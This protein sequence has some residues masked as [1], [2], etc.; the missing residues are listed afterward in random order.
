[1]NKWLLLLLSLAT[2]SVNAQKKSAKPPAGIPGA[3]ELQKMS[4]MTPAELE[5]YQQKLIRQLEGQAAAFADSA[6]IV[7]DES[8]FESFSIK[9]PVKDVKKLAGIAVQ[10][11]TLPQLVTR[12]LA[13]EQ[14]L[15][16]MMTPAQLAQAGEAAEGRPASELSSAMISSWYGQN[17]LTALLMAVKTTQLVPDHLPAWNN[18]AALF[19]MCGIEQQAVPILKYCLTKKPGNSTLLNNLGQ[20]Y[21][22]LGDVNTATGYF[23]QCLTADAWH[24]EANRS[25]AMIS[26]MQNEPDKAQAYF[27]KELQISMR[28]SSLAGISR[29][30]LR[31]RL[32]Y[33]RLHLQKMNR[34]GHT[35][36]NFF[37]EI[38]LSAFS[39]PEL[40]KKT[41]ESDPYF[42]QNASFFKSIEAEYRFWFMASAAPEEAHAGNRYPGLYQ[43]LAAELMA[44]LDKTY[45][46]LLEFLKAD[47]INHLLN[48]RADFT[49]KMASAPCPPL[50]TKP[51]DGPE[52]LM[53]YEK[54]CCDIK[55]PIADQFIYQYN[56]YITERIKITQARWKEYIN[57]LVSIV[58]LDPSAANKK[59]VYSFV[60]QYFTFLQQASSA[61]VKDLPPSECHVPLTAEQADAILQARHDVEIECPDWLKLEL[62]IKFAKLNLDCDAFTLEADAY[63]LLTFGMEKKFKTGSSTLYI[64]AGVDGS[65]GSMAS[66]SITQQLYIVFDHNN[67]F[68]DI[69]LRGGVS[70]DLVNGM[71]GAEFGYD[72]SMNSGF[73]AQGSTKSVWVEKTS[74]ALDKIKTL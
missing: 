71:V 43:D 42:K 17:P 37:E 48:M 31:E 73:N 64:G 69:G 19:N 13:M 32:N 5:K 4:K 60:A 34:Q 20:A 67:Q 45:L 50:V 38:A 6:G 11:P 51:G 63:G 55:T 53:A 21:L 33:A 61:G 7:L 18:L 27:E 59:K 9:P 29:S 68:S 39:L 56:N 12:A 72:F 65:F 54:K 30:G 74:A 24:P 8:V 23:N 22:G 25:M 36:R 15:E 16:K 49:Q 26:L 41:I 3:A 70:G 58:Q 28:R 10:P 1:M 62:S 66:G 14:V 57:A 52:V 46:P 40:P 47:D 35:Q 2:F 44:D